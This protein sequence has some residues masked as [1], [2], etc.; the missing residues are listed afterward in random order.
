MWSAPRTASLARGTIPLAPPLAR[1]SPAVFL[2]SRYIPRAASSTQPATSSTSASED[3]RRRFFSNGRGKKGDDDD[4]RRSR[5][6]TAPPSTKVRLEDLLEHDQHDATPFLRSPRSPQIINYENFPAE[7]GGGAVDPSEDLAAQLRAK[8]SAIERILSSGA[9]SSP[10]SREFPSETSRTSF[11]NSTREDE[12]LPEWALEGDEEPPVW[13]QMM[14]DFL[15]NGREKPVLLDVDA[16]PLPFFGEGRFCSGE[17]VVRG[18]GVVVP[19]DI[20][21]RDFR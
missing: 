4:Y 8:Q 18:G 2:V 13:L 7:E 15:F 6:T 17:G 5:R 16:S 21:V 9:P 10:T 19:E 1:N 12:V 20:I 14:G 11:G 3:P